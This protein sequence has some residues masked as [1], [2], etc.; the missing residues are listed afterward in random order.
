MIPTVLKA[1]IFRS[2]VRVKTMVV[3]KAFLESLNEQKSMDALLFNHRYHNR[4]LAKDQ[5]FLVGYIADKKST[6]DPLQR[7]EFESIG[8]GKKFDNEIHYSIYRITSDEIKEILDFYASAPGL[9]YFLLEPGIFKGDNKFLSYRIRPADGNKNIIHFQRSNQKQ[10]GGEPESS[11][12]F[13]E[14]NLVLNPSP[15]ARANLTEEDFEL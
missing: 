9:V 1:F 8:K 10:R 11:A 14:S 7:K 4:E 15:P 13:T 2:K 12:V 5:V 3:E 6:G